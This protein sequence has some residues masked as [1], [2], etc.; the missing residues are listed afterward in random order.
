MSKTVS[1]I[2]DE[3]VQCFKNGGKLLICGN[4][5][6][7][8]MANHLEEEFICKFEH[9]RAPL[10][11][12][13]LKPHTS[14]SNDFGYEQVFARQ[15]EALGKPGD[16]VLIFSTSGKSLNCRMAAQTARAKQLTVIEVPRIG[17][18]TAKIQENQL[19]L[20]H[21]IAREVEKVFT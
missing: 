14:T 8:A 21:Y 20:M 19:V 9:E 3:I 17:S 6:S 7:H 1:Y 16:V 4:G 2:V 12:I 13:S 5:G 11:A 10:P 18:S 15:I